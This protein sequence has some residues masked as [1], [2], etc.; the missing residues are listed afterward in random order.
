MSMLS[1]E[2]R[3]LVAQPALFVRRQVPRSELATAIGECL[4]QAF[5]VAQR[6]GATVAGR[7]FVRYPSVGSEVMTIEAGMALAQPATGDGA[8]EGGELVGGPMLVA[9]HAGHYETLHETY[10]TMERWMAEHGKRSAGAPWELYL[11]DPASLPDPSTWRTE[12]YWP[13]AAK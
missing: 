11:T 4:G 10:R 6:V 1:I 9:L 12:I 7:P 3:T 2:Q 8:V 13:I 5:G